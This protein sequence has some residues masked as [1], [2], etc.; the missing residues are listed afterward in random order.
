MIKEP[1]ATFSP[2]P[3]TESCRPDNVSPIPGLLLAGDWTRTGWP[4]TMESAVRSGFMAAEVDAS[5][6]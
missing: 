1:N 4:A 2:A 3:G 5:G 6:C